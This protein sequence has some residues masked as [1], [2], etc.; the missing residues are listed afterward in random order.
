MQGLAAVPIMV[1][2]VV[3]AAVTARP[4]LIHVP[5]ITQNVL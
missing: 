3:V 4:Y 1:V 2:S 5:R